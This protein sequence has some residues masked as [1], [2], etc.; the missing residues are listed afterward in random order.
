MKFSEKSLVV[1]SAGTPNNVVAREDALALKPANL[2]FEEAGKAAKADQMPNVTRRD[3]PRARGSDSAQSPLSAGIALC[4]EIGTHWQPDT[5]VNHD[6]RRFWVKE[7]FTRKGQRIGA[8]PCCLESEPCPWH[9]SLS[10]LGKWRAC[11]D[12]STA[13]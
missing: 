8:G 5:V 2:S 11:G 7:A 4:I 12:A 9:K 1:G 10:R 6:G 13:H 3:R